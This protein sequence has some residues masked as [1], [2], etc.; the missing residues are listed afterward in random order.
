[1]GCIWLLTLALEA[2]YTRCRTTF[3]PHRVTLRT[4]ASGENWGGGLGKGRG[5]GNRISPPLSTQ[6][7]S[8]AHHPQGNAHSHLFHHCL[9]ETVPL[10]CNVLAKNRLN[11][12]LNPCCLT[13]LALP[14]REVTSRCKGHNRGSRLQGLAEHTVEGGGSEITELCPPVN[15][16]PSSRRSGQVRMRDCP[17]V[18][19]N[20]CCQLLLI[21]SGLKVNYSVLEFGDG[22][23]AGDIPGV[24]RVTPAQ[25]YLGW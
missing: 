12:S 17:Q 6:S 4:D 8:H 22:R 14:L 3:P 9:R 7:E 16:G 5:H 13:P 1:M 10:P 20:F 25:A 15:R 11:R 19:E 2:L 18:G 24:C 21:C 23:C